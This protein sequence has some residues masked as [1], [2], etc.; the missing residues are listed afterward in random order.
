L[1]TAVEVNLQLEHIVYAE[2]IFE[3][4]MFRNTELSL[5]KIL[6]ILYKKL[7]HSQV[8][9]SLI[10]EFL[11]DFDTISTTNLWNDIRQLLDT[12]LRPWIR[13]ISLGLPDIPCDYQIYQP[14]F[15]AARELGLH[16]TAATG[17]QLP[18]QDIWNTIFNLQVDRLINVLHG[19]N[20]DNLLRYFRAT[21][22]PLEMCYTTMSCLTFP[23]AGKP[24][25]YSNRWQT[26]P[27]LQLVNAG[28]HVILTSEYLNLLNTS[29]TNEYI[30]GKQ[31]GLEE[32]F[33][34]ELLFN[35]FRASFLKEIEKAELADR[36]NLVPD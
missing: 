14:I 27:L 25:L 26:H 28:S 12:A 4:Q 9:T 35:S 3:P 16:T 22:I 32:S 13:G 30:L 5:E 34:N 7:Q 1:A 19:P 21:Q 31:L 20:D 15:Y 11:R 17:F 10:I 24:D 18:A 8:K 2:L 36:L 6:N 33:F 29:L 23:S